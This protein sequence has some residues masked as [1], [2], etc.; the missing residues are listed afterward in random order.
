MAM[1]KIFTFF[2][3]PLNAMTMIAFSML[4]FLNQSA[5]RA[6]DRYQNKKLPNA[7]PDI[8]GAIEIFAKGLC[9]YSDF[10]SMCLE[11]GF[12]DN[13]AS[14]MLEAN[15]QLLNGMDY[16]SAYRRG[17][18]SKDMLEDRLQR[19][20]INVY[21]RYVLEAVTEYFPTASDLVTFA[22][23]EVYSPDI[24]EKFG[25]KED[26]PAVFVTEAKKIGMS[27][28][29]ATNYW[30]AHWDLPSISQGFEMF[31]RGVITEEELDILLRALDVM[32][33]WREGLKKIAYNPLT[34][35]DVRRMYSVGVIDRDGVKRSYLDIGYDDEKAEL[36]TEFTIRYENDA[37]DG[38]TRA[39][40]INAYKDSLIDRVTLKK[41][42]EGFNYVDD[43]VEFWL[44]QA[45]YERTLEEVKMYKDS[46]I[47]MY[48]KGAIDE[49]QI[50]T[51]L[52]NEDLPA[53]YID[54]VIAEAITSK[55]E[56]TQVPSKTDLEKW[57]IAGY[58]NETYFVEK[59]RLLG[60]LDNDIEIYLTIIAADQDTETRKFLT[61]ETYQRW[62]VTG[63]IS[64]EKFISTLQ[65]MG[66]N[67]EDISTMVGEMEAKKNESK[68]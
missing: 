40:V 17:I 23:R 32:P 1:D 12:Y 66:Y 59:M 44:N 21:D 53:M 55:A 50:K 57:L 63:I 39:T 61:V 26:L 16:M 22:V 67:Q 65:S 6:A 13:Y 45:E 19:L 14:M 27:E 46:L 64:L 54:R 7:I 43:V 62:F 9:T 58:I 4:R 37:M 20:K 18:I 51:L 38:L 29:Q 52:L 41:Y 35:V 2:N 47:L 5:G 42:L 33:F 60:Y 28:E 31:H 25:Q 56:R 8:Y 15:T 10:K 49:Q 48:K 24:V 68:E 30:A 3:T 34:R 36:M 11:N